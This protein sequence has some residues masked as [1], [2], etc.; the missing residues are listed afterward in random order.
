MDTTDQPDE[1]QNSESQPASEQ[2]QLYDEQGQA[3]PGRGATKSAAHAEGL[4]H[5]AA[6]IWLWKQAPSTIAGQPTGQI[7]ILLQKR[8]ANKKTWPN[9][10]D[11]SAA[12]HIDL[13]ED[14]LSAA[15]RE[16]K[17]EIGLD[18]LP[19]DLHFIGIHL[20]HMEVASSGALEN[21]YRW[22]YLVHFDEKN[23]ERGF[24]LQKEEVDSLIW[25]PLEDFRQEVS[26]NASSYVPHGQPYF[27]LVISA[28][29]D[30]AAS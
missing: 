13:G 4:L 15:L 11:I 19:T 9:H 5:G 18:L 12:G 27:S 7:E 25:K 3:I 28:I 10:L 23:L 8:A 1:T 20:A 22:I 6:H 17:E 26:K 16:V 29:E 21:E 2:W 24:I 30:I 14:P